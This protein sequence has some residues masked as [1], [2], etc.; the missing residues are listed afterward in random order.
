[1]QLIDAERAA[2]ML[3]D[4]A[5]MRRQVELGDLIAEHV[6]DEPGGQVE[7]EL[8]LKRCDDALDA[9]AVLED[10]IE[11]E[12]PDLVVIGGAREPILVGVAKG[13]GALAPG[14]ILAIGDLQVGN[15]LVGNGSD[16]SDDGP[17]P[18]TSLAAVGARGLL[19]AH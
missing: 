11:D 18:P 9:H 17:L 4:L 3:Q 7:E 15:G 13:R 10:A 1:V 8:A 14:G 6:R 5:T 12:V 2:E 19:G 16:P